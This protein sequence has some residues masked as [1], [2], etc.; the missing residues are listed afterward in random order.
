[1]ADS[2]PAV[3]SGVEGRNGRLAA[4]QE[5]AEGA[6]AVASPPLDPLELAAGLLAFVAWLL[7][8]AGGITV[9]TQEYIDPIRNRTA[10]GPAQVVGCLLVIA[11]CHTVTNTAMLCC[12][13]AFLGV[14]GF[15]AIGPAPG[16]SAT[17]A[18]RRDA[19]LAAVT[20]GF[21]IFLIIQSGTVVLSDQAFTNLSLDKYIRLAG[22][23]SLFSFTVGY[24]PDVFRQLMDRVNGNLNAAGKK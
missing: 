10:S 7:L 5:A 2:M 17:A 12:V 1:M 20:R 8:M 18:G 16:S 4:I 24:N 21:F 11:T 15:R 6:G 3:E 9:G 19:Y 14:L 13:S 23:S 22:I